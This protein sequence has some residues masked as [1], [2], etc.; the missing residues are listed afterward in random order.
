M[1]NIRW[2]EFA[3]SLEELYDKLV[4]RII[5]SECN[6][7]PYE[8]AVLKKNGLDYFDLINEYCEYDEWI[9]DDIVDKYNLEDLTDLEYMLMISSEDGNAYYQYF[10]YDEDFQSQL[11][12]DKNERL[13]I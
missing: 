3:E 5:I 6:Y 13:V 1:R 10:S 12:F 4:D 9:W 2:F 7:S 8:V 11:K